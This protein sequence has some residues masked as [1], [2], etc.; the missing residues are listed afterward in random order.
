MKKIL[1]SGIMFMTCIMHADDA[2]N[3]LLLTIDT[4]R[5]L[6]EEAKAH[7]APPEHPDPD[8]EHETYDAEPEQSQQ[9]KNLQDLLNKLIFIPTLK[10]NNFVITLTGNATET[11]S[12]IQART[13]ATQMTAEFLKSQEPDAHLQM[14][15]QV[16]DGDTEQQDKSITDIVTIFSHSQP[17]N[18]MAQAAATQAVI[19][20]VGNITLND[21]LH[22]VLPTTAEG[23]TLTGTKISK[24]SSEKIIDEIEKAQNL[25]VLEITIAEK[26]ISC[27]QLKDEIAAQTYSAPPPPP[28]IT[29]E[30]LRYGDSYQ[31][32]VTGVG[33][34]I[35][36]KIL[37][38]IRCSAGII[39]TSMLGSYATAYCDARQYPATIYTSKNRALLWQ[40]LLIQMSHELG[41]NRYRINIPAELKLDIDRAKLTSMNLYQ[42]RII[43]KDI[44]NV[45]LLGT[46]F[47]IM[48]PLSD[49]FVNYQNPKITAEVYMLMIHTI[50]SIQIGSSLDNNKKL[51]KAAVKGF[52]TNYCKYYQAWNYYIRTK[53][54]NYSSAQKLDST[55][56]G[57]TFIRLMNTAKTLFGNI[58][59]SLDRQNK[60]DANIAKANEG[61]TL[62]QMI[63][64]IN[65]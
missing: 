58:K 26:K 39:A 37:K 61:L 20:V 35:T 57:K 62:Q 15:F 7:P 65:A 33:R 32:P 17:Q 53:A 12:A 56:Y 22:V 38:A 13:Q 27:Q 49:Y 54:S 11:Q 16:L 4:Y 51:F 6:T 48:M 43:F 41:N 64:Y 2:S 42:Q 55:P 46:I 47:D 24:E 19:T 34:V 52:V 28:V 23:F 5:T 60:S 9:Y 29:M 1:I 14:T 18:L 8:N 50:L 30:E 40:R 31:G 59:M 25:G 3:Q 44:D 36:D 63:N 45:M 10:E 21:D